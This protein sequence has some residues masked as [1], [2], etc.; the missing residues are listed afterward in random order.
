[1]T[2]LDD[3]I[4]NSSLEKTETPH[5]GKNYSFRK[6]HNSHRSGLKKTA[7]EK[8]VS[9]SLENLELG[10]RKKLISNSKQS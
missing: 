10:N 9:E 8:Y 3:V 4:K 1:L 5:S 2:Y 7:L 6:A